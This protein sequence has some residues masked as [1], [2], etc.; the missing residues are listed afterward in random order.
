MELS[1]LFIL[2][3]LSLNK[4]LIL[5]NN[6]KSLYLLRVIKKRIIKYPLMIF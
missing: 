4:E 6:S 1:N 3:T 5:I 2:P